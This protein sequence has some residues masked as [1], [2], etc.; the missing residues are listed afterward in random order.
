MM[1][2]R[3]GKNMD[4]LTKAEILA[5]DAELDRIQKADERPPRR[6]GQEARSFYD[7]ISAPR[8]TSPAPAPGPSVIASPV[9]LAE[10]FKASR[11]TTR[12][13]AHQAVAVKCGL[14][15]DTPGLE[16][17]TLD[18]MKAR[19]RTTQIAE[20]RQKA[21]RLGIFY[22]PDNETYHSR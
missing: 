22:G 10:K 7:P 21:E 1:T 2:T 4:I 11:D 16:R 17:M 9:N 5:A 13:T 18:D 15:P 12:Y 3:K 6:W 8:V 20:A 19:V 14:S